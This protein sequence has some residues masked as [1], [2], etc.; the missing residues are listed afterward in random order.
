MY[1]FYITELKQDIILHK[2]VALQLS[3]LM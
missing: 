1:K 3:F 2:T